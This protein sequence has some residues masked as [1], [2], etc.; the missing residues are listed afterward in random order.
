MKS[1]ILLGIAGCGK[2]TQSDLIKKN[3]GFLKIS[4]G[5]ILRDIRK[6]PNHKFY[7]EINDTID[8]GKLLTD[9]TVNQSV[10]DFII[11]NKNKYFGFFS[12]W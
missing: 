6:N 4:A 9:N 2:G 7:K 12:D 1:I 8:S 3:L 10:H 11:S 5:D